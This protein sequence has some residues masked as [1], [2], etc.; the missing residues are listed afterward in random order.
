MY[1]FT[2]AD[3]GG[4]KC[5]KNA[6]S[7]PM[8]NSR[9]DLISRRAL[10]IALKAWHH[11]GQLGE[12]ELAGLALVEAR[13]IQSGY[14]AS[15]TG[16]GL[17]L[18]DVLR[19]A[20]D[21]LRPDTNQPDLVDKRSRAWLILTDR[22]VHGRTPD[23]IADSLSMARST[24]DHA[25]NAAIEALA[26]VLHQQEQAQGHD[27]RTNPQ[28]VPFLAPPR[29][30][31]PLV[32]RDEVVASITSLLLSGHHR[33]AL[34][35]LPGVG[36]TALAIHLASEQAIMEHF[37]D[38]ILW[39]GLGKEPHLSR[40]IGTW[41]IALGLSADEMSRLTSTEERVQALRAVIG[42]RRML[43]IFDDTWRSSD[44]I[45]MLVGGPNCAY[46]L[47]TRQPSV[48]VDFSGEVIHV[49]ELD[50]AA[51][52]VL[53]NQFIPALEDDLAVGE[54][55][56]AVGSLPLALTLMG[57]YLRKEGH[58]GQS[59]RLNTAVES[60]RNGATRLSLSNVIALSETALDSSAQAA[61]QA[62][63]VF[64]PRPNSF[65]EDAA[66]AIADCDT[67]SLDALV[68]SGL[69][70]L[71]GPDR[72]SLH[73]TIAEYARIQLATVA[74]AEQATLLR[75][76]RYFIDL[77][78]SQS[79]ADSDLMNLL[80]A[81]DAAS[82]T[83][84][85]ALLIQ[86][87]N[88]ACSFLE[89][90]GLYSEAREYLK[91]AV[92]TARTIGDNS[93]LVRTLSNLGRVLHRS[94]D[95]PEADRC[96]QEALAL[97]YNLESDEFISELFQG[98]GVVAL[99]RGEYPRAESYFS[100]GLALARELSDPDR[101]SALLAN[102]GSLKFQ[103]GDLAA[104]ESH[105]LEALE[106]A[107]GAELHTRVSVLLTNLGVLH[108]RRGDRQAA[109]DYFQES[110][111]LAQAA[112]NRENSV[113][114]LTNL[115]SLVSERGD[116]EQAEAYYQ[117]ALALARRIGQPARIS[118][119]AA[120]L[121]M[122]ATR[123]GEYER[124]SHYL[125]EGLVVARSLHHP[126]NIILNLINFGALNIALGELERAS[127]YLDEALNTA[128]VIGHR[129]YVS[130]S[131]NAWGELYLKQGDLD[132]AKTAFGEALEIARALGIESFAADA[133]AGLSRISKLHE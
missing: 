113:F 84:D 2:V 87:V 74:E 121:G 98:L 16:Y 80:V 101:L 72:Y 115:G 3:D 27:G 13:R 86:G 8:D 97:A 76:A 78:V 35:G 6:E 110:L 43:L 132:A 21:T 77:A 60:L 65:T 94:G 130:A 23:Y 14:D 18:R 73:A 62:L 79:L 120:N 50:T 125:E 49:P 69:L 70:D 112:G 7:L 42:L 11:A 83:A 107:R 61:L 20:L 17:A 95:Y 57:Q 56:E 114:L 66:L 68:D 29:P 104:A 47:T 31:Y 24:Y 36:K 58:T 90:Q 52:K 64:P 119:L 117:E 39:A 10:Q 53:L 59:R 15:P 38:G 26:D 67:R 25:Q 122:L 108:A 54:L 91:Q 22:Y 109:E 19:A 102:M 51:G 85:T 100:D 75:L 106:I 45:A 12:H 71:H 40:L 133:Q 123:R 34:H 44:A 37:R 1:V 9:T 32:G 131:L 4:R 105:F 30:A 28:R 129:Q 96:Y 127:D 93:A 89:S 81:L 118:Q 103:Q 33:T 46:L 99:T 82:N 111:A 126:E 124:A 116:S 41:G 92:D 63:S 5:R 128:R 88:T 48:A 55:V